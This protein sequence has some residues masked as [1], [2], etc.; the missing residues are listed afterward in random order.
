M[1]IPRRKSTLIVKIISISDLNIGRRG[2][3]RSRS[4]DFKDLSLAVATSVVN[5]QPS[6]L[7]EQIEDGESRKLEINYRRRKIQ[8]WHDGKIAYPSL[9]LNELGS[10]ELED[11]R[12][13]FTFEQEIDGGDGDV[14]V[15]LDIAI[16]R[17]LKEVS[18]TV[19]KIS[20]EEVI[21]SSRIHID[22]RPGDDV[23]KSSTI[24]MDFLSHDGFSDRSSNAFGI[25]PEQ[26]EHIQDKKFKVAGRLK[27]NYCYFVQEDVKQEESPVLYSPRR[28]SFAQNSSS[29][30]VPSLQ[31]RQVQSQS[32][33]SLKVKPIF[34][35]IGIL[36]VF[37]FALTVALD[38]AMSPGNTSL[39][40]WCQKYSIINITASSLGS[41]LGDEQIN[42]LIYQKM[43]FVENQALSAYAL[44]RNYVSQDN[45]NIVKVD[46]NS[47]LHIELGVSLLESDPSGAETVCSLYPNDI[48]SRLCAA[49]ARL[50][51]F[52]K[53]LMSSLTVDTQRLNFAH[54]EFYQ[55]VSCI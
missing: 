28:V 46:E 24:E 12:C 19:Q 22:V 39:L 26:H 42:N 33:F 9:P 37:F 32:T 47:K 14:G 8:P 20:N 3:F 36:G 30:T 44:L 55:L 17:N 52:T 10:C 6:S 38:V 2:L 48:A 54:E 23:E 50:K 15:A 40:A 34:T 49:E 11:G 5:E 31:V 21:C 35:F 4:A 51:L 13:T 53:A 41:Y 45:I 7:Q 1:T 43:M 18:G 27:L 29:Y 25:I 16:V